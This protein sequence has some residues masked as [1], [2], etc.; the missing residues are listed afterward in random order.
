MGIG[1][2]YVGDERPALVLVDSDIKN[3]GL[4]RDTEGLLG[5]ES[6]QGM[7][8]GHW[9]RPENNK[10]Y[11]WLLKSVDVMCDERERWRGERRIELGRQ[12]AE[13]IK[14]LDTSSKHKKYNSYPKREVILDPVTR[15]FKML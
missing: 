8:V 2:D 7:I 3:S 15:Q 4:V 14:G 9:S 12:F 1:K 11:V 10:C 13:S 6:E 5:P